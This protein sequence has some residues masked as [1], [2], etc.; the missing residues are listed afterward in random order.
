MIIS[1]LETEYIRQRP[2]IK[3]ALV[4]AGDVWVA[5]NWADSRQSEEGSEIEHIV[6]REYIRARKTSV[7]GRLHL[8]RMNRC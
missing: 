1:P 4:R 6:E 7:G 8:T 5:T 2:V 3:E